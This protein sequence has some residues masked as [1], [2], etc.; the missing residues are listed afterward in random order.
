MKVTLTW[1]PTGASQPTNFVLADSPATIPLTNFRV[2]GSRN[3]QDV[4]LF[5]ATAEEFYDRGNRKTEITFD[6]TRLFTSQASAEAF[7]LM[8]ETQ[9][10]GQFLATFQAGA[11]GSAQTVSRYLQNAVVQSVSS[12]VTGCTTRHTYK[13]TGGV[14]GTSPN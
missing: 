12:S 1:T 6:T 4:Q 13:I 11:S 3:I 9:F 5:R 7:V 8:H 2:N 14:M 10:P